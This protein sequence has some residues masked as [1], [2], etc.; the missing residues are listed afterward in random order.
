MASSANGRLARALA[1][2]GLILSPPEPR[3]DPPRH[4]DPIKGN[5]L[6]GNATPCHRPHLRPAFSSEPPL[7]PRAAAELPWS[8]PLCATPHSG[9]FAATLVRKFPSPL[10]PLLPTHQSPAP[11]RGTRACWCPQEAPPPP[12]HRRSLAAAQALARTTSHPSLLLFGPKAS[13]VDLE[14]SYL[15]SLSFS[16]RPTPFS[17]RLARPLSFSFCPTPV[18]FRFA[19]PFVSVCPTPFLFV[20]P[21]LFPFASPDPAKFRRPFLRL[22]R[23]LGCNFFFDP[24]VLVK[25]FRGFL[26]VESEDLGTVFLKPEGQT[27]SFPQS[28]PLILLSTNRS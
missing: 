27:L 15:T 28:D 25:Y 12:D 9:D 3:L 13:P 11:P 16:F 2:P 7:S 20:S 18:L 8:S 26:C 4:P 21:D 6:T 5:P 10:Q 19:R 1:A 17:F 23:G 24:K 14:V 22:A